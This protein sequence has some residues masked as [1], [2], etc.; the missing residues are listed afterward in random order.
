[1]PRHVVTITNTIAIADNDHITLFSHPK[2]GKTPINSDLRQSNL[3]HERYLSL[4]EVAASCT[5]YISSDC[6]YLL[7]VG[8]LGRHV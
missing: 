2:I 3:A 5:S 1:M 4:N 6:C 8:G 7:L